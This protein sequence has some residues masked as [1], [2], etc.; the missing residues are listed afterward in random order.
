MAQRVKGQEVVVQ[1]V[2]DSEV[3]NTISD[4]RSFEVSFQMEVLREG[5]L[6]ET[7]NRRDSIFTGIAGRMELHFENKDIFDL[8]KD[9]LDKARRRTPG[10]TINIQAVLNMPNGER[11]KINILDAEF[12]EIPVGF[13]SRQDYGTISLTFEAAEAS[14]IS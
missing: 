8:I 9:L 10:A 6:G 1:I 3:L 12:G 4:I 11:P 5:Y 13:G 14:V 2:K 7:T